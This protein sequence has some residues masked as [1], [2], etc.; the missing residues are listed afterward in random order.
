MKFTE[1]QGAHTAFW[2]LPTGADQRPLSGDP[3]ASDGAEIDIFEANNQNG[4][5]NSVRN[6]FHINGYNSVNSNTQ[7]VSQHIENLDTGVDDIYDKWHTV[8][9]TWSEDKIDYWW[10]GEKILTVDDAA[11]IPE[12]GQQ[13]LFSSQLA[14]QGFSGQLP[15]DLRDLDDQGLEVDWVRAFHQVEE[16]PDV[17]GGRTFPK[18]KPKIQGLLDLYE[19]NDFEP[20]LDESG[21]PIPTP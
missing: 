20:L 18:P 12:V 9:V 2:L 21:V 19:E 1:A 5:T 8:G 4:R 7:A 10:E 17:E 14:G 6:G 11:F 15:D 13:I 3:T 16:V